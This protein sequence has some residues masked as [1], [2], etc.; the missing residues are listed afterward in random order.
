M[1]VLYYYFYFQAAVEAL[2][3]A[4]TLGYKTLEI[5]TDSKYTINGKWMCAIVDIK[6]VGKI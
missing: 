2:K 3:T 1:C 6:I 5:R 4:K